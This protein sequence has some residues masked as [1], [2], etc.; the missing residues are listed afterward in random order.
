MEQNIT[1]AFVGIEILEFAI[2]SYGKV[3][4][5]NTPYKYN[6]NIEHRFN[7]D[8]KNMFV[9][10][11]VEV[12][13]GSEKVE[14][15]TAKV[16]CIYNIENFSDFVKEKKIELPEN[17]IVGVNSISLSTTRGVLFTLFRGTHLHNLILPLIDTKEFKSNK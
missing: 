16:S 5:E 7:I 9:I 1:F 2:K 10:T 13:G 17:F 11:S 15:C 4:P 6:V 12:F 3:I 14:L 8:Q